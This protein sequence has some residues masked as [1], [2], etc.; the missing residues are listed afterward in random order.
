VQRAVPGS[1]LEIKAQAD[2]D[3]RT[4][5]TSFAKFSRAFPDFEFRYDIE[6]G[7]ADVADRLRELGLTFEQFTSDR[8]TR[9]KRLDRLISERRLDEALRWRTTQAA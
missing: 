6:R 7:A 1:N 9:L 4:Y 5:R 8:F 2:A 3:Q